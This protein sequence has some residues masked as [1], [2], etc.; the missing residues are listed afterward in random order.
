MWVWIWEKL[1]WLIIINDR[2][3]QLDSRSQWQPQDSDWLNECADLTVKNNNS[4][5]PKNTLAGWSEVGPT[6]FPARAADTPSPAEEITIHLCGACQSAHSSAAGLRTARAGPRNECI[7]W[8]TAD[9]SGG[10]RLKTVH[11]L[12]LG[13]F[14][15][16]AR[17]GSAV[18]SA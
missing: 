5:R 7:R 10:V 12:F 2:V 3:K 6:G 9:R 13:W 8:M 18:R 14:I 11:L 4:R 15:G 17:Q 1:N 16:R